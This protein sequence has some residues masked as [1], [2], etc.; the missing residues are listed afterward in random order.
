MISSPFDGWVIELRSAKKSAF[1]TVIG[2][3]SH[4]GSNSRDEL[5]FDKYGDNYYLRHILSPTVASLNLDVPPG[6]AEKRA[7]SLE[8]KLH[9]GEETL[10][11][12]K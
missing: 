8:A 7:R 3:P 2:A 1:V 10:V 11:A 9:N 4:E 5:V 12:A 6:K